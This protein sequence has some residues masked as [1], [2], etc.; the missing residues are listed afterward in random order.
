[1]SV[2][3][4]ARETCGLPGKTMRSRKELSTDEFWPSKFV[5]MFGA[6]LIHCAA[7]KP[8]LDVAC[9]AGRNALFLASMGAR[10]ICLDKDLE[11]LAETKRLNDSPIVQKC[12]S[13]IETVEI[14]LATEP[15]PIRENSAGG[16]VNVH[17]TLPILFPFFAQALIPGGKLILETVPAHGGNYVQLPG[18]GFIRRGLDR[19]FEIEHYKERK[20]GP[21]EIDAVTVQ[22][23]AGRKKPIAQGLTT[24]SNLPTD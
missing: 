4:A 17:F 7:G 8:I 12:F 13:L 11:P 23:L 16:V 22:L 20:V 9:G 3:I 24:R 15:W 10:V 6:S 18:A 21:S 14:D 5:R 19:D 2:V 1:V